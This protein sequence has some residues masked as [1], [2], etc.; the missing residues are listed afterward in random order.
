MREK[1]RKWTALLA[2]VGLIASAAK[3]GICT[4]TGPNPGDWDDSGHWSCSAVPDDGDAVIIVAK[5]VNQDDTSAVIKSLFLKD[6]SAIELDNDITINP[7][8]VTLRGM[9]RFEGDVSINQPASGAKTITTD[10]V[11]VYSVF[12]DSSDTT[13]VTTAANASIETP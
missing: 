6:D 10:Y 5:T 2:A 9:L 13:T 8:D 11:F 1:Q 3:A 12:E 7:A 4:Y